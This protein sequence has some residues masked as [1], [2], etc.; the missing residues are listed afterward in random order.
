MTARVSLAHPY[1]QA[2]R[3]LEERAT[4][5]RC[6]AWIIPERD[7]LLRVALHEHAKRCPR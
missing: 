2:H 3:P 5:D 4:C 7:E 1:R 6:G